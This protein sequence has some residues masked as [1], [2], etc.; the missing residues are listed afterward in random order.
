MS[1]SL[2]HDPRADG[3]SRSARL[4]LRRPRPR[5]RGLLHRWAGISSIA[6]GLVLVLSA[7]DATAVGATIVFSLG[8]TA[9]LGVSAVVH[10]RDWPIE[11]VELLVRLD[12][13]AIFLMFAT[14]ATPVAL[15]ALDGHQSTVLFWFA[16]VGALLGI[17]AEWVP[18]HPPAGI[19][20]A[21][22]LI[23]GCSFLLFMPWLWDALSTAQ[24][25]LL[26]GGGA[27]YF[28]GSLIVG[29]QRPDPWPDRFGYHEIWHVLVVTA[30]VSHYIMV[31]QLAR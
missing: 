23:F 28:V 12:H 22:Y 27:A 26:L 8:A 1:D 24:I 31:T 7:K 11:R 21:A 29:S 2:L 9:M 10:A 25:W 19:M 30:A 18:V 17:A 4:L 13:S 3:L 5:Y 20:N 14:S 15:L 6:A 16:W